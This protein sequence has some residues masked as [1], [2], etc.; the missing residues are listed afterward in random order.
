MVFWPWGKS[1][2]VDAVNAVEAARGQWRSVADR[3]GV[4]VAFIEVVCPD[5]VVHRWHLEGQCRDIKGFVEPTWD[6]VVRLRGEFAPWVD[7]RLVLD[8]VA[9]LSSNVVTALEFLSAAA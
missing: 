6:A 5:P 1:V 2:I 7:H 4:P 9:D 3:R 8:T